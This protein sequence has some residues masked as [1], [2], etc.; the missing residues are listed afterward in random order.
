[1]VVSASA[2]DGVIEA[3]EISGQP[4]VIGVQWH[5]ERLWVE[6]ESAQRLFSAFVQAAAAKQG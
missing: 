2:R 4:F 5:P 1:M 6:D 3:V